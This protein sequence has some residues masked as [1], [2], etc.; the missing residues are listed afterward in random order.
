[1]VW[2]F[3]LHTVAVAILYMEN[4][5]PAALFRQLELVYGEQ[6]AL[7][8]YINLLLPFYDR[9][10]LPNSMLMIEAH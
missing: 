8:S 5:L 9:E 6:T 10:H 2:T 7:P 4:E 3:A 1:M